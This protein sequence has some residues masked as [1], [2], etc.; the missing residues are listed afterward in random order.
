MQYDGVQR[1]SII[2]FQRR[3]RLTRPGD[4]GGVVHTRTALVSSREVN[5]V[6]SASLGRWDE[7]LGPGTV[8]E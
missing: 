4:F 3:E 1:V 2:G 6:A 8:T 5:P 7:F